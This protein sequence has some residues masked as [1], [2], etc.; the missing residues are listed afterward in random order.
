MSGRGSRDEKATTG[1]ERARASFYSVYSGQDANVLAEVRRETYGED[2]GQFSW[3]TA[4]ELRKF[5]RR[6]ELKSDSRVLDVAC[7]AGGP[8][9]FTAQTTGCHVSGIDINEGGIVAARKTAAA[10]NLGDRTEFQS[11]DA[12]KY[13]PFA[14]GSFDAILS[15][16]AMNH[17]ENRGPLLAEWRRVLR[18]GGRFLFTDG[19]IVTGVLTRAEILARSNSMG[20]FLFTPAGAHEQLID[21]AGFTD[22]QVEDV[23]DTITLVSKRWHEARAKRRDELLKQGETEADF[24]NLQEMLAAAH[25][26][27]KEKR[28]SRFAY[29][30]RR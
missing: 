27:A 25:T 28:L 12:G 29:A 6:L 5:F 20:H 3:A 11:L 30:A 15:I 22:L 17:L 13:L 18:P 4:D 14:A 19:V 9:L 21:E 23:T 2:I 16:D 7:G 10:H 26:L 1:S 8:A 24:A